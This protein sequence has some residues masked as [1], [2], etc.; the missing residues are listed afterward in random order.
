MPSLA[1][2]LDRLGQTAKEIA[3]VGS[4]IGREFGHDLVEQ[5]AQ[6]SAPELRLGLD[7]LTDAAL[8]FCRGNAP[9]STYFFKHAL[10]RDAAYGTLLR[11]KRQKLHARVA[12]VQK[13]IRRFS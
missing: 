1:A 8:L 6:R 10:I 5:V 4:V 9:Q 11:A 12:T 13:R 3:Q 7:R 2:R